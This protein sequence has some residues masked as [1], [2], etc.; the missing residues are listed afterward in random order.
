[1]DEGGRRARPPSFLFRI[2]G[3]TVRIVT[4][5]TTGRVLHARCFVSYYFRSRYLAEN[6]RLLWPWLARLLRSGAHGPPTCISSAT[7]ELV[8]VER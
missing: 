5:G 1:M 6:A 7:T 3:Y 2:R 8:S 4:A